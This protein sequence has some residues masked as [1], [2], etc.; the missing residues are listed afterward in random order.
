MQ[1]LFLEDSYLATLSNKIH[2]GEGESIFAL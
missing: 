2:V 1:I